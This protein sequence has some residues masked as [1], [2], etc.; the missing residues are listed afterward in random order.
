MKKIFLAIV[1]VCLTVSLMGQNIKVE[2]PTVKK[3]NAFVIVIDNATFNA[4]QKQ[5]YDY[6]DATQADGLSTY[7]LRGD[8][9]NPMQ[10]RNEL[11][12]LYK[13]AKNMEGIV[14]I[15][16]IPVAMVR[17]AQHMT[18]A[19]KMDED[20]FDR[21]ESSVGSD[22]FYDDLNLDFE[23]L[24]RDSVDTDFFYYNLKTDC[25]QHLNPTYYSARIKYPAELGGDKYEA[26]ATF[27]EKCVEAHKMQNTLDN[28]VTFAGHGYNSD[29][30]ITWMDESITLEENFQFVKNSSRNLKQL[31]FRH[32]DYMKYRLFD[33]LQRP[34][35]D[36]IFFNE[37]GS[38]DKQHISEIPNKETPTDYAEKYRHGWGWDSGPYDIMSKETAKRK[39]A[40]MSDEEVTEYAKRLQDTLCKD[41]HVTPK[42]FDEWWR[43]R[44]FTPE[45]RKAAAEKSKEDR[46]LI[47]IDLKDL[48]GFNP[49]PYF[50][51]F[52]ACYNGSFH[53]KGNISG[54]YIFGNGRT[55]VCQGNTVNVLQD[56]WT[57]ECVGIISLGARIGEYNRLIYYVFGIAIVG[58][59]L[60]FFLSRTIIHRQLLPLRQLTR[61]AG[62]ISEGHYDEPIPETRQQDEIGRLQEHFQQMQTSLAKHRQ[63]LQ[64]LLKTLRSQNENLHIAYDRAKKADS[65]KIAFLHHMTNQMVIPAQAIMMDVD[66]L[67]H[68]GGN[69]QEKA[70]HLAD[71]ID[72]HSK[73]ITSLLN[74]IL[75][76]SQE[77]DETRKEVSD[78][79]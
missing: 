38:I 48:K 34:E 44:N 27:L 54:Y 71:D 20:K 73:T 78:G 64:L 1:S 47:I 25:A 6:R 74:D 9:E 79:N 63:E 24:G 2:K 46:R 77:V 66:A 17:N 39:K 41:F 67:C 8:W 52:N 23:Y 55:I 29:C 26:I 12:K 15:G 72:E 35:V 65:V 49:Q 32:E 50:V 11:K 18:T 42:F 21:N 61:A 28:I 56:K 19:F 14:L 36:A 22:R 43:I 31:N 16:D 69:E 40:G 33:E 30:L 10:L 58:I 4:C 68:L 3:G 62:R 7:I 76:A 37:H 70:A 5:V 59:L 75:K 53:R 51:M 45:E 57:Y 13:K 60:L